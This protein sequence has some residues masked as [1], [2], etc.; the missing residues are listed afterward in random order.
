MSGTNSGFLHSI[1]VPD[2][3]DKRSQ[4][5]RSRK[6]IGMLTHQRNWYIARAS[7]FVTSREMR[8]CVRIDAQFLFPGSN[9]TSPQCSHYA[10]QYRCVA[11]RA[12]Y[13]LLDEAPTVSNVFP[14]FVSYM[15]R[16]RCSLITTVHQWNYKPRLMHTNLPASYKGLMLSREDGACS[17]RNKTQD[18]HATYCI[19]NARVY[20]PN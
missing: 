12:M 2:Q 18:S 14:C 3:T 11:T 5:Y 16:W 9:D 17:C 1:G 13:S 19:S 10:S 20:I 7:I 15:R 8:V 4:S 6:L